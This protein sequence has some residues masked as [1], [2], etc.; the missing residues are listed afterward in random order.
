[1][2]IIAAKV[3]LYNFVIN[4][5]SAFISYNKIFQ[6]RFRNNNVF[7]LPFCVKLNTLKVVQNNINIGI[8]ISLEI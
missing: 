6:T 7:I 1:M 4:R 5:K 2:F 8:I 3:P